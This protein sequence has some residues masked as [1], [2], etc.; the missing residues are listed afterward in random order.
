M[1][2]PNTGLDLFQQWSE[3]QENSH[4]CGQAANDGKSIHFH[5]VSEFGTKI[6]KSSAHFSTYIGELEFHLGLGENDR[7]MR[8]KKLVARMG[9]KPRILAT[10]KT[11]SLGVG[12][13]GG[14]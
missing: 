5:G 9:G 14:G 2:A 10:R 8:R 4:Q 3:N 7:D 1:T 12:V 13:G 6:R 11:K